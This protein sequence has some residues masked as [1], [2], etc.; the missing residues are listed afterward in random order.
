M[1]LALGLSNSPF[2]SPLLAPRTVKWILF[3]D[4]FFPHF[5]TVA[6]EIFVTHTACDD[7]LPVIRLAT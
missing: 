4:H 6:V 5:D 7:H 2:A 3:P 1:T